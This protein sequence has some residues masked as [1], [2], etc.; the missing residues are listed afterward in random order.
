MKMKTQRML[1]LL[2]A[3]PTSPFRPIL[4]PVWVVMLYKESHLQQNHANPRD[5][6]H[7]QVNTRLKPAEAAWPRDAWDTSTARAASRART[8]TRAR[9]ASLSRTA[10]N[11]ALPVGAGLADQGRTGASG[12][13]STLEGCRSGEVAG[14]CAAASCVLLSVV[15]IHSPAELLSGIAHAISAVVTL[16]W[17]TADTIANTT[18]ITEV[19]KEVLE[20]VFWDVVGY[21]RKGVE[22]A[23]A[24]LLVGR[25][26]KN[27]SSLPLIANG[28]A[29]GR[30]GVSRVVLGRVWTSRADTGD[31]G[32]KVIEVVQS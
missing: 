7:K 30:C 27:R 25:W 21:A 28:R 14:R 20:R 2:P 16:T 32:G 1:T 15:G 12:R 4:R 22:H 8:R 10:S 24:K 6:C 18:L 31:L 29:S 11:G 9:A 26:W 13:W 23:L 17:I 3:L 5:G 19:A